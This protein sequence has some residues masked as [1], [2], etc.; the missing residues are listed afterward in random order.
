MQNV[1]KKMWQVKQSI[2]TAKQKKEGLNKFSGYNYYTP[3]QIKHFAIE[4]EREHKILFKFD[5]ERDQYGCFGILSVYDMESGEVM[6]YKAATEIPEIKATNSAQQHGGAMTY[7]ERY[8]L[9]FAMGISDNSLDPDTTENTIKR[10]QPPVKKEQT[11]VIKELTPEEIRAL[12]K[13]AETLIDLTL[14]WQKTPKAI[15]EAI[16][17][18]FTEKRLQIEG[19]AQ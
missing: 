10:E 17:S 6:F 16:G 11:T 7:T 5:F 2:A 19:G 9:Q 3:E 8:L 14:L 13:K 4:Q 12:I 15:R 1:I 18:E